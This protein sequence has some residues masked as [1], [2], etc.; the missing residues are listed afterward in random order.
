MIMMLARLVTDGAKLNLMERINN[1]RM[2][3]ER[4]LKNHSYTND[5]LEKAEAAMKDAVLAADEGQAAE[6]DEGDDGD[7]GTDAVE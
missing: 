6:P 5:E 7:G 4:S 1:E 2:K 3:L